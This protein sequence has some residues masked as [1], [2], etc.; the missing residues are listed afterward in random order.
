MTTFGAAIDELQRSVDVVERALDAGELPSLPTFE[1]RGLTGPVTAEDLDRYEL[2]M[3][4]LVVCQTRLQLER[5][6]VLEEISGLGRKRS[7]ASA[8]ATHG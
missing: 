2:T 8:Y 7:A 5:V 1:P 3:A 4:R 6:G